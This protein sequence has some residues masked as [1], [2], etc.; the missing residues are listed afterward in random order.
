ML[1]PEEISKYIS[2]QF[3][4]TFIS[5]TQAINKQELRD[6]PLMS[7]KFKRLE[8]TKHEYLEYAIFYVHYNPEKHGVSQKFKDHKFSSYKA[9]LSESPTKV[10]KSLVFEIF[11][12]KANFVDFHNGCHKV[13][14]DIILQ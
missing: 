1:I 8:I 13:K 6:G 7:S 2:D 14:E 11:Q 9:I 4:K 12:G 10:N 3:R 5:Y